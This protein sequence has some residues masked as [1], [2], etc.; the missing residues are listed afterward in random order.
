MPAD[1]PATA[2]CQSGS[3]SAARSRS[4]SSSVAAR[5]SFHWRNSIEV[6]SLDPNQ[7]AHPPDSRIKVPSWPCQKPR[8]PWC[9]KMSRMTGMGLSGART[10]PPSPFS[11]TWI[12]HLTSSTGVRMKDVMA[13]EKAP[14]VQSAESGSGWS[15][16]A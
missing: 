11:G 16:G 1:A 14:V 6:V 4:R 10:T 3:A 9:R 5:R 12:L 8:S 7:A 13:P 2:C 15:R